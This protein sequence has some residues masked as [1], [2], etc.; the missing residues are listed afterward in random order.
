MVLVTISTLGGE[1]IRF[2]FPEGSLTTGDIVR[3]LVTRVPNHRTT[4][5]LFV[6]D[7]ESPVKCDAASANLTER[8]DTT[9]DITLLYRSYKAFDTTAELKAAVRDWAV[10]G[11]PK[12]VASERY[13][14]LIGAW[15]TSNVTDMCEM[16]YPDIR[17]ARNSAKGSREN[18][19]LQRFN[20][21]VSGW[22]VSNVTSMRDMFRGA[23]AFNGDVR[24]WDTSS[25]T[26]MNSM[27][28]SAWEFNG[29][30]SGWDVSNVT[31]MR[32]MFSGASAFNG[33]VSR[34]DTS[35]VTDMNN[36]FESACRFSGDVSGWDVSNVTGMGYMFFGTSAFNGDLSGWDTSAVTYNDH[37]LCVVPRF[38]QNL[39]HKWVRNDLHTYG[40]A[41]TTTTIKGTT[42]HDARTSD[43][44]GWDSAWDAE[45]GSLWK[46]K[47][48][49]K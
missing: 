42:I 46:K 47:L 35:R 31:S 24:R 12:E 6:N 3:E 40:I 38:A 21:D 20:D 7:S 27:F 18:T 10:G 5:L 45:V 19:G 49:I 34:W 26:D 39:P 8:V 17:L 43:V 16:F 37:M 32:Y 14:H 4:F 28:K 9:K 41:G 48:K 44:S 11:D 33:D 30:V 23:S 15:D 22:D 29:D 25:V 2:P 1:D 36:M 13:G